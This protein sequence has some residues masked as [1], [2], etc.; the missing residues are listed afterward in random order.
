MGH[1]HKPIW[2]QKG[3][4]KTFFLT[5]NDISFHYFIFILL[6][7]SNLSALFIQQPSSLLFAY[8]VT[9]LSHTERIF[10]LL[11]YIVVFFTLLIFDVTFVTILIVTV[12]FSILLVYTLTLFTL[13]VYTLIFS[14]LFVYTLTFFTLL[15]YTLNFSILLFRRVIFS[16]LLVYMLSFST[17]F[18][19]T[20]IFSKILIHILSFFKLLVY[21][22]TLLAPTLTSFHLF[23]PFGN[24][25]PFDNPVFK[26]IIIFIKKK[27][28]PFPV[29]LPTNKILHFISPHNH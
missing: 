15:A 18:V 13:L 5:F 16:K 1:T 10:T 19:Y 9:L 14:I 27:P 29:F 11:V 25:F 7:S 12:A 4:L 8:T 17:L 6:D 28:N 21:T 20:L 23:I 22:L 24:C 26:I 2:F 3:F